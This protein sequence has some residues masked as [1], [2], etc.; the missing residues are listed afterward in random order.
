[1][2]APQ[3]RTA[4]LGDVG[5]AV[6]AEL[7]EDKPAAR[8]AIG[9][10]GRGDLVINVKD[11][12][13]GAKGDGVTDDTAAIRAA[14]ATGG[15]RLHFPAGTYLVSSVAEGTPLLSFTGRDGIT[16]DATEAKIVNPTSYTADT[17][18]AAFLFDACKN[19]RV[20]VR[21]YV[22]FTLPTPLT[23]LGYRGSTFVRLINGCDGAKLDAKLT[24]CRYGLQSGEY[25]DQTKGYNRNIDVRFRTSFCGYPIALYL[26]EGV[27]Y[28]IDADDVHRAAYLAGC[29]DVKGTARWSNQYI[30]DAV[31][32]I[33]DAKTGTGTSRGCSDLDVAS[34][35]KGSTI[36]T[37]STQCASLNLSRVDPGTVFENIRIRVHSTSTDTISSRVGGF[38]M[39]SGAKD[40]TTPPA[41]YN[42]EP[43]ITIRNVSISGVLDH[44]A[45]TTEG[46]TA[47]DIFIRAYDTLVAHSATIEN[48]CF[49]DLVIKQ[50]S[51]NTRALWLEAPGII[52]G[53]VHFRNVQASNA[54]LNILTVGNVP[55]TLTN[56]TLA[57]LNPVG[58][59]AG[60]RVVLNRCSIGAL[61]GTT[62]DN[63]NTDTISS[64][65]G[66]AGGHTRQKQ[67]TIDLTGASVNWAAAIPTGAIVLGV[68]SIIKQAITGSSGLQIG[69]TGALTRYLNTNTVAQNSVF[70]P[71][72]YDPAAPSPL[73]YSST[74]DLVLTSKTAS[75]TGGQVR[76]ILTYLVFTAPTS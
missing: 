50:S 24:N 56:C 41:A 30:A 73:V 31:T 12:P 32:L 45:Q 4:Y 16:I 18:T 43:S 55:T 38:T 36:F 58:V 17:I 51:G 19:I 8:A 46:N 13:Y 67:I 11:A 29:V 26:A 72:N 21:E 53:G 70:G 66:G 42:W 44:S 20:T 23:H 2:T 47:G 63:N 37:N 6:L 62:G 10:V 64:T 65:I 33:T 74:T 3:R 35:D 28:D 34:I 39:A 75:F 1:M 76:V 9:A 54:T 61:T 57:V 68:Q 40:L 5:T 69:V 14:A 52:N 22:G 59:T 48:L 49:E 15:S 60:S 7:A 25:A 27:R 71:A